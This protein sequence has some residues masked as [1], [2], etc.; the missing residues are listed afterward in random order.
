MQSNCSRPTVRQPQQLGASS[1]GAVL[2][3]AA[4]ALALAVDLLPGKPGKPGMPDKLDKLDKLDMLDAGAAAEPQSTP[5]P[6]TPPVQSSAVVAGFKVEGDQLLIELTAPSSGRLWVVQSVG[7]PLP[8]SLE[9][10]RAIDLR[11]QSFIGIPLPAKDR[12]LAVV[13]TGA[14]RRVSAPVAVYPPEM[15]KPS[16]AAFRALLAPAIEVA[17]A[18]DA[19]LPRPS[20]QVLLEYRPAGPDQARGQVQ[21]V[22]AT[23]FPASGSPRFK[24]I[25]LDVIDGKAEAPEKEPG[26]ILPGTWPIAY[27]GVP[28]EVIVW[29]AVCTDAQN[30]P[31]EVAFSYADTPPTVLRAAVYA[32]YPQQGSGAVKLHELTDIA[33]FEDGYKGTIADRH[34]GGRVTVLGMNRFGYPNGS[35][36]EC[37]GGL[38]PAPDARALRA[39]AAAG[40]RGMLDPQ[41]GILIPGCVPIEVIS[42]QC[43]GATVVINVQPPSE[44]TWVAVA[45]LMPVP[46]EEGEYVEE[47]EVLDVDSGRRSVSTA[48]R[49]PGPVYAFS[50]N[51]ACDPTARTDC[52]GSAPMNAA[53]LE[54]AQAQAQAAS[55]LADKGRLPRGRDQEVA[56]Q[57]ALFGGCVPIEVIGLAFYGKD[58]TVVTFKY[59]DQPPE[60]PPS[61][62]VLDHSQATPMRKEVGLLKVRRLADGS[63]A[64]GDFYSGILDM[65]RDGAHI[66]VYGRASDGGSCTAN[67]ANVR[68]GP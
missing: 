38:R 28:V 48:R 27:G 57:A 68:S 25:T 44:P 6:A 21:Q 10:V 26:V 65:A 5:Q 60:L 47:W 61:V 11:G 1:L 39:P 46:D 54:K 43:Q 34:S 33:V 41:E 67:P 13:G 63:T 2:A 45:H 66:S 56:P 55:L 31:I 18:T 3:C 36:A 4:L 51:E 42:V 12:L 59:T 32:V 58:R 20:G 16:Q 49:G 30:N 64:P 23:L 37:G 35:S 62:W 40:A 15:D 8:S 22:Q 17:R 9:S 29:G 53:E 50:H 14:G 7:G 19:P 52:A 24:G